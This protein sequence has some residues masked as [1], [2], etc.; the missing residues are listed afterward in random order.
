MFKGVKMDD[1]MNIFMRMMKTVCVYPKEKKIIP[2]AEAEEYG[3]CEGLLE[4][5]G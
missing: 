3:L 5:A 2:K 4:S 1:W